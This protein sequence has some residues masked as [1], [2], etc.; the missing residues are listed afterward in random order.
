MQLEKV[1]KVITTFGI[2]ST[3]S[4]LYAIWFYSESPINNKIIVSLFFLVLVPAGLFVFYQIIKFL[5]SKYE[6]I[7]K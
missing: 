4:T 5:L 2:L 7:K 3:L 1:K 6:V